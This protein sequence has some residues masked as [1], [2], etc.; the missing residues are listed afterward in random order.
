MQTAE[1]REFNRERY[2]VLTRNRKV[3]MK[4]LKKVIRQSYYQDEKEKGEPLPIIL[5]G[6]LHEY[7]KSRK[8]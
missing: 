7:N 5:E 4:N 1:E 3:Q 6:L 2:Q 8:K